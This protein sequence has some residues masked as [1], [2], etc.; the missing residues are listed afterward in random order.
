MQMNVK[1][2]VKETSDLRLLFSEPI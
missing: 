2:Q 1:H